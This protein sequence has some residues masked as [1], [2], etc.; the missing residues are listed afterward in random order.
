M[1]GAYHRRL[2]PPKQFA[3]FHSLAPEPPLDFHLLWRENNPLL[4]LIG[5]VLVEGW[6]WL[7]LLVLWFFL[8][9]NCESSPNPQGEKREITEEE[10][11]IVVHVNSAPGVTAWC[12]L[13]PFPSPNVQRPEV[14]GL[15][16][17]PPLKPHR[18]PARLHRRFRIYMSF[19]VKLTIRFQVL[20]FSGASREIYV[21]RPLIS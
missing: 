14:V 5:F 9:F 10:W 18:F 12:P 7:P 17:A 2:P 20:D 21:F 15:L 16:L 4:P 1:E 19:L 8:P 3:G 11:K 6:D 13:R